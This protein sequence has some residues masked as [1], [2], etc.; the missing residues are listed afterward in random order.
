MSFSRESLDF[1]KKNSRASNY[2]V[3]I[4]FTA[5]FHMVEQPTS[6]LTAGRLLK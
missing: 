4:H 5:M 1:D 3:P 6:V 2:L